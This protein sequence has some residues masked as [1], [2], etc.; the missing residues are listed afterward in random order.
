MPLY[1]FVLLLIGFIAIVVGLYIAFGPKAGGIAC[2]GVGALIAIV[3]FLNL[4]ITQLSYIFW[5]LIAAIFYCRSAGHRKSGYAVLAL[6][7]L[8]FFYEPKVIF[9]P[10]SAAGQK[11]AQWMD[12]GQ[13]Q[14]A[15]Q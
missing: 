4:F 9:V 5:F 12:S 7:I 13:P 8:L 14:N 10:F 2:I 6:A 1:A 3:A 11:V 15:G